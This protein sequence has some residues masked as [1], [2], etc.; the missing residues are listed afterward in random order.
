[1][2]AECGGVKLRALRRERTS[3]RVA[4]LA[5]GLACQRRGAGASPLPYT[6]GP[7]STYTRRDHNHGGEYLLA[8]IVLP[9]GNHLAV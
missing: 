6:P 7:S 3:P 1:M 8:I 2:V 4:W 5:H 9:V